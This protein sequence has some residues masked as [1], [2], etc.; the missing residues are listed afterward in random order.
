MET[1]ITTE[2]NIAKHLDK[3]TYPSYSLKTEDKCD[4]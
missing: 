4:F 3:I 2:V 1:T